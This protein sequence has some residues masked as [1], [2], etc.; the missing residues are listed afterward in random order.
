[1]CNASSSWKHVLFCNFE[2]SI[3]VY[4]GG[5]VR[6]GND[7]EKWEKY[8]FSA[9]PRGT[10]FCCSYQISFKYTADACEANI[11][12]VRIVLRKHSEHP[13]ALFLLEMRLIFEFRAILVTR[14]TKYQ[15]SNSNINR[16]DIAL[17][18]TLSIQNLER[19]FK[20]SGCKMTMKEAT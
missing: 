19:F 18:S 16:I 2:L 17:G 13:S 12:L 20:F 11:L 5:N 8:P 1:M 10:H 9:S 4:R 14:F 3:P 7:G 6:N 15:F